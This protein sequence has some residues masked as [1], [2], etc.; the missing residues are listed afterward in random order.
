MELI[1]QY[2]KCGLESPINT[3]IVMARPKG[4]VFRKHWINNIGTLRAKG[5]IVCFID[6][7]ARVKPNWL[8]LLVKDLDD[9]Q[10]AGVSGSIETWNKARNMAH[11]S[12]RSFLPHPVSG[13]FQ[14]LLLQLVYL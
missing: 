1:N 12:R 14:Y 8:K 6:S 9:S 7:D 3:W 10:V 4:E 13:L 2:E 5:E 11:R